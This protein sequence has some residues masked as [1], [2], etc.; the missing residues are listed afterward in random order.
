MCPEHITPNLIPVLEAVRMPGNPQWP[1]PGPKLEEPAWSR[2]FL[3][4]TG[5]ESAHKGLPL[6]LGGP[7]KCGSRRRG[8][9]GF[10]QRKDHRPTT[11]ILSLTQ[12]WNLSTLCEPGD[13]H[14]LVV[15]HSTRCFRFRHE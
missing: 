3:R 2:V 8:E 10:A 11:S 12:H 9:T 15:P 5:A 1:D 14:T 6:L 7:S 4:P 13:T